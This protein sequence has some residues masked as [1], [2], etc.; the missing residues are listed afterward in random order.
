MQSIKLFSKVLFACKRWS[1]R[2]LCYCFSLERSSYLEAAFKFV[3]ELNFLYTPMHSKTITIITCFSLISS[4]LILKR[5][6]QYR[7]LWSPFCLKEPQTKPCTTVVN[8]SKIFAIK[9]WNS[10]MIH[11][12]LPSTGVWLITCN[13]CYRKKCFITTNV[14][15]LPWNISW[16][17]KYRTSC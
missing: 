7:K 16:K 17:V 14:I 15:F 2:L 12:L 3:N 5:F 8:S 1:L 11:C 6:E 13:Q 9:G 10:V 4:Y